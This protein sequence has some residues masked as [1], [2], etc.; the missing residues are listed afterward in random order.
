MRNLKS[1]LAFLEASLRQLQRRK[2]RG[3]SKALTMHSKCRSNNQLERNRHPRSERA[4]R[5]ALA[6]QTCS[7]ATRRSRHGCVRA[8][9]RIV[10]RARA[11]AASEGALAH[12]RH[13]ALRVLLRTCEGGLL[14]SLWVRWG[15]S[16][17]EET[18]SLRERGKGRAQVAHRTDSLEGLTRTDVRDR[19]RVRL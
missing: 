16:V 2:L 4:P 9:E 19:W 12:H 6:S 7:D 14:Q 13:A 10:A 17:P 18:F 5:H 1:T 8:S 15:S 3:C 11:L